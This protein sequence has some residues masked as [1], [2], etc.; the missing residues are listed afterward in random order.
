MNSRLTR[1]VTVILCV[2]HAVFGTLNAEE[3]RMEKAIELL[4]EARGADKPVP[5]LEKAINHLEKATGNKNGHRVA[6]IKTIKEAI[7]TAES[8]GKIRK[9]IGEAIKQVRAGIEA[10]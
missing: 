2:M 6:A 5:L 9:Q 7:R 4:Q 1:F 8:G 10:H 3:P